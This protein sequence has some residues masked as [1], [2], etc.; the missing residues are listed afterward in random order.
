MKRFDR[1]P[2]AHDA[3]AEI[4]SIQ[5]GSFRSYLP[6]TDAGWEQAKARWILDS[7][8][9]GGGPDPFGQSVLDAVLWFC[10][11]AAEVDGHVRYR[12]ICQT[13]ST[14]RRPCCGPLRV[15]QSCWMWAGWGSPGSVT[16]RTGGMR[17][18]R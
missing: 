13:S 9:S 18:S 2:S 8:R 10:G 4:G 3:L 11:P 5:C 1:H 12:R 16:V 7:A 17:C 15:Q 6:F 14:W